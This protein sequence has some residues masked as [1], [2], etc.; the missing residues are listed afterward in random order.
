MSAPAG[1]L[2]GRLVYRVLFVLAALDSFAWG[3]WA[4]LRPADLF[5]WLQTTP[6][7]DLLLWRLLGALTIM[8]GVFLVAAAARPESLGPLV[9]VPLVGRLLAAVTWLWLLGTD[10][11]HLPAAPLLAL[12]VH[13]GL[14]V[15]LFAWFIFAWLA[16]TPRRSP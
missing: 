8:Q 6:P 13:D 2:P 14:W 11:V 10:R 4:A 9:L 12:A 3:G 5:A 1:R 15:P 7:H 16:F